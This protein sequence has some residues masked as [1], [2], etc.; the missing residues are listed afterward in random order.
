MPRRAPRRS[1]TD[2]RVQRE[3]E[4]FLSGRDDWP[5]Y[6]EWRASGRKR[7]HAEA[8]ARRPAQEWA[9]MFG[10]AFPHRRPG[11]PSWD[12]DR[13]R[14]ELRVALRQLTPVE[15]W[16]VR[17]QLRAVAGHG[18]TE[19]IART[20]GVARWAQEFGIP[21][22]G[23]QSRW[24]DERIERELRAFLAERGRD[25]W[26]AKSEF[27][28]TGRRGLLHA[29]YDGDGTATWAR[30]LGVAWTGRRRRRGR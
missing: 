29:I 20:G 13:V 26:P 27:V 6:R 30:R 14:R 10:V 21:T 3:L 11:R 16:P 1:W 28:A 5:A 9:A 17:E 15:A 4:A 25:D 8:V 22:V 7:L 23:A 24:T 12:E 19:A 2:E 18:L